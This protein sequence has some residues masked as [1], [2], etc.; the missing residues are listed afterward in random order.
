M[1]KNERGNSLIIVLLVSLVFTTLGLAIIA[2]SIGGAKRVETRESDIHITYNAVEII[3]KMI[4]DLATSIGTFELEW[5]AGGI[6]N[7]ISDYENKLEEILTKGIE[8]YEKKDSVD[9]LT[10]IDISGSSPEYVNPSSRSCFESIGKN[11]II[12]KLDTYEID[13]NDDFTRVF[14]IVL[15]TKNPIEYEGKITRTIRK[16][17]I[18]SP[19]PSFLKYAVGSYSE[20]KNNG[21]FLNGSANI[22]GN[23]YANQM[24]INEKAKYQKRNGDWSEQST[25]MSSIN[26]DIFSS[27]A[28]LLDLMKEENFYKGE[29]PDLKH[30]SQFINIDFERTMNDQTN[31]ILK[32]NEL[33][34]E[35]YGN[36]TDFSEQLKDEISGLSFFSGST[37][38]N[39]GI[40]KLENQQNPLSLTGGSANELKDSYLIESTEE[41][42]PEYFDG[43]LVINSKYNPIAFEKKLA[44]NGDLYIVSYNDIEF[45]ENIHVSGKLHILNF[46][47]KISFQKN[48][49]SADSINVQ[50]YESDTK[51]KGLEIIGKVVTGGDLNL[52]S[53]YGIEF[54]DH[55][56]ISGKLHIINFDGKIAF[57]NNIICA[58]SINIKSYADNK[59]DRETKGLKFNGD[60]V[61]G[62]DLS[63][64]A[65][66]TA[67]EFNNIIIVND[68]L[69]ITG[70][71]SDDGLENDEIIFDSVVYAGGKAFLSNVNI[72]GAED[73][74]KQLVLMTK[75]E[76]EITR[77]NEFDY[78]QDKDEK[79]K[80][81]LPFRD[82]RIKPLKA[83]FY[84]EDNAVLYGVGSLFYING[85]IFAKEKLEINAVRGEVSDGGD[86][87][88]FSIQDDKF[89]RF[90]VEYD[91]D[92]LLNKFD[93]L[94]IV[95]HVQ[96]FSDELIFE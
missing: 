81:Y 8:K 25:P 21:L 60:I 85:G 20:E 44:V 84:T 27:T 15:V 28:N 70:D 36:G 61:T 88:N 90:I 42:I 77:M 16:R 76:L 67:I 87:L 3:E 14:E 54:L 9:C 51:S 80:P 37:D 13:T 29:I 39:V 63:V 49:I 66:N 69:K 83:F 11:S 38:E 4:T 78:F 55:V 1:L 2:S 41:P 43:D 93:A 22:L 95:N 64:K 86:D 46:G 65:L 62:N 72:L 52:E 89:S 59:S 7:N 32:T 47:G 50:S 18:L 26:G 12:D 58:D 57:E 24:S 82:D 74:E 31:K 48:I 91:K 30:D 5:E 92:V 10:V 35:R 94:P 34:T 56:Y 45:L 6:E 23:V 68:N 17:F 40:Q 53:Y 79:E 75:G 71:E 33:S 73:N 19:L 96:I